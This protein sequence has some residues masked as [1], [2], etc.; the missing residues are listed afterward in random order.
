MLPRDKW[1]E[2]KELTGDLL[3]PE[4]ENALAAI[5]KTSEGKII[6]ALF[7]QLVIHMEP[8]I[9]QHPNINFKRLHKLLETALKDQPYFAFAPDRKVEGMCKLVGMSELPWKVFVKE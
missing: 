2:M 8:L 3:I 6:G 7:A 4:S 1:N 5:A 9:L